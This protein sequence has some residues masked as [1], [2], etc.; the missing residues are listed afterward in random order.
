M[1]GFSAD[2]R[3]S[4]RGLLRAPGF[5]AVAVLALAIGVGSSTAMFSVVDAVL[6]RPLPYVAPERLMLLVGVEGT[7]QRVPMGAVEFLELEKRATTVEAI[8][9]FFPHSATARVRGAASTESLA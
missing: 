4:V 1:Q 8:G 5:A 9:A 2:L 7:G 3:Q 6:L